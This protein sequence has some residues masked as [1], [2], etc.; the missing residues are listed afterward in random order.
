[1]TETTAAPP[2]DV[3]MTE[4]EPVVAS[5]VRTFDYTP[6]P[7]SVV[8]GLGLSVFGLFGLLGVVGVPLAVFGLLLSLAAWWKVRQSGGAYG[9][10]GLAVIGIALGLLGSAGGV[11]TQVYAYKTEVPDGFHR[12]SFEYDISR[13][14][15]KQ[16]PARGVMVPKDVMDLNGND[17]FVKGYM[18]PDPDNRREGIDSFLL[19][20]DLGDCC[21][22]G[23][24]ALTD[25]IGVEF[26]SEE[27]R[28]K[29]YE[30]TKVSVA[31][32]FRIRKDFASGENEPIYGID[33]KYFDRSKSAF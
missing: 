6:V 4:S 8:L 2:A 29:F 16:D 28:A 24:P 22:G 30:Q 14:G 1:M 15:I 33:A 3:A 9:G 7:V 5:D 25:M 13:P 12:V 11:A 31:G 32:T 19:V 20:K 21:F 17:V 10:R 23:Q 18:Y 26:P 27:L